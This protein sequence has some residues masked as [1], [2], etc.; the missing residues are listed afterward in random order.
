MNN[1]GKRIMTS[2]FFPFSHRRILKHLV[3]KLEVTSITDCMNA[4]LIE[5]SGLE[6]VEEQSEF[7]GSTLFLIYLTYKHNCIDAK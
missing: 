5:R 6:N 2:G 4:L 7:N 3:K 1:V